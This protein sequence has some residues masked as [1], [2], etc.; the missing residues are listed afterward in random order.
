MTLLKAIQRIAAATCLGAA[1]FAPA[2]ADVITLDFEGILAPAQV[3]AGIENFYNGGTSANGTSGANYGIEFSSNVR[4]LCLNVPGEDT[5]SNSSHGGQGVPGSE[6]SGLYFVD[7]DGDR[8][9]MNRAAGFDTR[10]EFNYAAA[11][12]P[13]SVGIWSGV[14]GTGTLLATLNLAATPLSGCGPNIGAYCPFVS[15]GTSFSGIAHSV[16][17]GG[18]ANA[19]VFDDVTFGSGATPPATPV[20]E[21]E[22]YAMLLGGLGLLGVMA[23]RRQKRG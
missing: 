12:Y 8:M 22:T 20:P 16:V 13:G 1:A 7:G 5:C 19:I 23:R 3:E 15:A 11:Y 6:R 2:H 17:F 21:P 9:F 4:A 10:L 14:N 18:T